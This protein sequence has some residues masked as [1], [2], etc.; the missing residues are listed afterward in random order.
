M[1]DEQARSLTLPQR[2]ELRPAQV[3]LFAAACG[4]AVANLYY[5]QPLVSLIA[6]ALGLHAG[7]VGFIVALTQLV[8]GVGLLCLVPLSD[9]FENRRLVTIACG[10]VAIGLLGVALS[11]SSAPFM[12]SSLWSAFP[13]SRHRFW[14]HSPRIWQPHSSVG[15]R[16]S[17]YRRTCCWRSCWCYGARC[18]NACQVLA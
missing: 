9:V 15:A 7:M 10:T 6:P 14:C 5:C 8:Y 17:I 13:R 18:H 3:A 4:V 11:G 12:V 16:C 1:T 2:G